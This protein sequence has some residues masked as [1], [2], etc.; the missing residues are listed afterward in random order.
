MHVLN[1]Y[2]IGSFNQID[3]LFLYIIIGYTLYKI[4]L[5]QFEFL[6]I[7]LIDI[8]VCLSQENLHVNREILIVLFVYNLI[9]INLA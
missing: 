8:C 7:I 1:N 9:L 6:L 4:M 2:S 3:Y 5:P